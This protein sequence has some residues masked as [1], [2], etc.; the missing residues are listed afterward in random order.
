[1]W[2]KTKYN[3]YLVSTELHRTGDS[4]SHG[5]LEYFDTEGNSDHVTYKD[6]SSF[7]DILAR[8]LNEVLVP[9][10]EKIIVCNIIEIHPEINK[11]TREIITIKK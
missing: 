8:F 2:F 9:R 4:Y 10:K 3:V 5:T 7:H 6:L 11:E 1:M